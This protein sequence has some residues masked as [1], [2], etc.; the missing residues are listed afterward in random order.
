MVGGGVRGGV[1][2]GVGVA[3]AHAVSRDG[4]RRR[5]MPG[6]EGVAGVGGASGERGRGLWPG[7]GSKPGMGR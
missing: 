5:R 3:Y 2:G 1:S 7:E 4:T 6:L